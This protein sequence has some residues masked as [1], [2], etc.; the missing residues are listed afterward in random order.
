MTSNSVACL[1]L[2]LLFAGS[3]PCAEPTP[4]SPE[5]GVTEKVST[6]EQDPGVPSAHP[7]QQS[8]TTQAFMRQHSGD[9][10]SMR[11]AAIAG[12][13]DEL[14][15]AAANIARD[16]WSPPH[17]DDHRPHVEVVRGAA[18]AALNAAAIPAATAALGQL[19]GACGACHQDVGGPPSTPVLATPATG[20]ES[21][22]AHA[23]AEEALWQGLVLPSDASWL[24]GARGLASAPALDSDVADVS[25]LA[26]RTSALARTADTAPL[27]SRGELYGKILATCSACH[28]RLG[29]KPK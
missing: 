2:C 15:R 14:H 28:S 18:R 3:G 23:A 7:V 8:K 4:I 22:V 25:A 20:D 10:V 27:A 26:H 19:G 16:E 9:A 29:V 5:L 13:L 12:Q 11:T 17:R 6:P 21:M 24:R 1:S